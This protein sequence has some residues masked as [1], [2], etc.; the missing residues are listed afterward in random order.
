[1]LKNYTVIAWRHILKNK[2]YS[3]INIL[4]LVL[5][6]SVF[7][8]GSLL[9]EY[10]QSHDNFYKNS[11]RIFTVGSVF[12][13][14][15]GVGV[16]ESDAAHTALAPVIKTQMPDVEAVARTINREFL[17]SVGDN[18]YYEN[19]RFSDSSFLNIFD[20]TYIE[21]DN[22]AIDDPTGLLL[23]QSMAIKLFGEESALGKFVILDHDKILTVKAVIDD[24]PH[25]T[26]F[27]SSLLASNSFAMVAHISAIN[28][29][30]RNE[31]EGNWNNLSMGDYT[32]LLASPGLG[33]KNLQTQLDSLYDNHYPIEENDIVSSF[34]AHS[35]AEANTFIWSAIGMPVIETV[36]LLAIFVLIV[37]IVN[38][39][40]LA[41]AQSLGRTREVGLRKTMGAGRAQL[42]VQFL[43]ESILIALISMVISLACLEIAV[44]I[45]N[46]A[47]GKGL[48][49]NYVETLPWLLLTTLTVGVM[50]GAY[51]AHLITK[52]T[53]IDALRNS[54][55]KGAKGNLFR[56]LMLGVQFSISIFILAIVM[57]VYFQ[58]SKL[59]QSGDIYAR[60]QII[61]LKRLNISGIENKLDTLK[62][63]LDAI[64][65]VSRTAFSSQ[66][67]FQQWNSSFDVSATQGDDSNVVSLNQVSV[68]P[69]F[70]DLYDMPILKGRRLTKEVSGDTL[71]SDVYTANVVV[72]ELLLQ[73][74]GFTLETENPIFYDFSDDRPSRAYSIVGVV[75]DQN[76]LGFHNV[77]K[78]MAFMMRPAWYSIASLRVEGSNIKSTMGEIEKAWEDVIPDYPIQ[79]EYLDETFNEVF[80]VFNAMTKTLGGFAFLAITLSMVGLFGMSAFMVERRTKEIG[81]RKV[82]GA[83][84]RQ[85]V[86]LLIWQFSKP[87]L[88]SL[89][90]AL[91]AAYLASNT[92]LNFFAD[93]LS[94]PVVIIISAG[95]AAT[96][97]SWAIISFHSIKIARANPIRSLRY[98]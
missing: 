97:F 38:Y 53:P 81:I 41:T 21:G 55:S 56:S 28:T 87:V 31:E 24:L 76:F 83:N 52:T 48:T 75:P 42:L 96:L 13:P 49:I 8:F 37:A 29:D 90:V 27:T 11:T 3:S 74:L 40:N 15:A 82:M 72:N 64:E 10:E 23:T 85:I 1:M 36:Q 93:R 45:F 9:A 62:N 4:G 26:H 63:E 86:G 94:L 47:L 44:P 5:G 95:L 68:S 51:P 20:F 18:D 91:P 14:D 50:A 58:N 60:S 77:I 34:R 69:T 73:K 6:L 79:V 46:A 71:K 89:A 2:L 70:F 25:N 43:V 22:T 30:T 54:S 92:Y 61:T 39:T 17:I 16:L 66:V 35:I 84:L 67:P 65:N 88:C 33:K 78:P 32:Y 98:E 12:K 7:F 59:E 19:I 57:V 80:K